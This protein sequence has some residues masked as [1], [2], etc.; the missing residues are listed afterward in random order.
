MNVAPTV[1]NSLQT[2]R[3]VVLTPLANC[4]ASLPHVGHL[5]SDAL[6]I[7]ELSVSGTNVTVGLS[8][9]GLDLDVGIIT[10]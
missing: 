3:I 8:V 5:V 4:N 10:G 1:L 7:N 6:R 9:V 2:C